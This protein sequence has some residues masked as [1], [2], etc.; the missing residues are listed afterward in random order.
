MIRNSNGGPDPIR[1]SVNSKSPQHAPAPDVIS[2]P[3]WQAK[4]ATREI[5][6]QK[7]TYD[8]EDIPHWSMLEYVQNIWHTSEKNKEW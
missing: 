8:Q 3:L 1:A 4:N 6:S 7:Y 5:Q 2:I